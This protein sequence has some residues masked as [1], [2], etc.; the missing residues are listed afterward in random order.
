MRFPKGKGFDLA[1]GLVITVVLEDCVSLTGTFLGDVHGHHDFRHEF[2]LIQLTR[3]FCRKC[4]PDVPEGTCVAINIDNILFVIPGINC[5]CDKHDDECDIC[6]DE[7]DCPCED[8]GH[9]DQCHEKD[10]VINI[11]CNRGDDK[12]H[13]V[14]ISCYDDDGTRDDDTCDGK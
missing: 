1:C 8:G 7:D 9:D 3:P 14:N 5:Q 13:I 11:S 6:H 10:H 12:T 4:C 2:I